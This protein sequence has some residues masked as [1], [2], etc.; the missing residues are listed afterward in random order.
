LYACTVKFG[1]I[2]IIVASRWVRGLGN[3]QLNRTQGYAK[4]I[5]T[6]TSTEGTQENNLTGFIP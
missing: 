1:E 4:I 3:A 2:Y 5:N 6:H